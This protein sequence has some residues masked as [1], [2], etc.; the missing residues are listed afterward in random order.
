MKGRK[1]E[2][3]FCD[4]SDLNNEASVEALFVDRLLVELNYPDNQVLRKQS[5]AQITIGKGSKKENY[6]PDYALLNSAGE[7]IIV[8]DAKS[9]NE[10][11]ENYH[12]QV[13]AYAL[14]LNQKYSDKNPVRYTIL[15]NGHH[16]I[17]YPW[18]NQEPVFFLRFEDFKE[19]NEKMKEL[20]SN[21]S[22]NVFK[23]VALTQENFD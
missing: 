18:D 12:Y 13:S 2:N 16:F 4:V 19:K 9:P 14:Y 8:L 21:I 23:Q 1:T 20:R 3:M 22:Y 11:P 7:P 10:T 6:K 15:T 17:V 5:I